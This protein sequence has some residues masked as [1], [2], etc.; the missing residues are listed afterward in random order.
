MSLRASLD[1]GTCS[2]HRPSS[3]MAAVCAHC[4]RSVGFRVLILN[5]IAP[6]TMPDFALTIVARGQRQ[7]AAA[8]QKRLDVSE[9]VL[10]LFRRTGPSAFA[11]SLSQPDSD[12]GQQDEVIGAFCDPAVFSRVVQSGFQLGA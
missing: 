2:L 1:G 6:S 12:I 9:F 3:G 7:D 10:I 5:P 4:R 11:T 8:A